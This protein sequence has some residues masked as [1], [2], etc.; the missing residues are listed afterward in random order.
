MPKVAKSATR[1]GPTP[2]KLA[3]ESAKLLTYLTSLK[4]SQHSK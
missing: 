1:L 3:T 4:R 2:F